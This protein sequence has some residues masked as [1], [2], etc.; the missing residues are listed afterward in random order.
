MSYNQCSLPINI[1]FGN[2]H[3]CGWRRLVNNATIEEGYFYLGI[4]NDNNKLY[5]T[6]CYINPL[7]KLLVKHK[8]ISDGCFHLMNQ[9]KE[10][11]KYGFQFV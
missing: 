6:W 3:T 9:L 11:H 2:K 5:N 4:I 1:S 7:T 8:E 10:Y